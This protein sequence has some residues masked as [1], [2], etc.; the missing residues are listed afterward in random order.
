MNT[1]DWIRKKGRTKYKW[2]HSQVYLLFANLA[3]YLTVTKNTQYLQSVQKCLLLILR[4]EELKFAGLS[5]IQLPI[6]KNIA[7]SLTWFEKK[8]L[9]LQFG[10]LSNFKGGA[11]WSKWAMPNENIRLY[12]AKTQHGCLCILERKSQKLTKHGGILQFWSLSCT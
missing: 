4:Q 7:W 8:Y 11:P 6:I 9:S 2:G 3:S 5:K 12:I 1:F 10:W